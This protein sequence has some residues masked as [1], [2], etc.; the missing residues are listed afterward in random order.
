MLNVTLI[1]SISSHHDVWCPIVCQL[2]IHSSFI[3]GPNWFPRMLIDCEARGRFVLEGEL[4]WLSESS[5]T[6]TKRERGNDILVTGAIKRAWT[7][8]TMSYYLRQSETWDEIM[9]SVVCVFVCVCVCVCVCVHRKSCILLAPLAQYRRC[10]FMTGCS[11][12]FCASDDSQFLKKYILLTLL[13]H[14]WLLTPL[15][16]PVGQQGVDNLTRFSEPLMSSRSFFH[17]HWCKWSWD[18]G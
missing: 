2:S 3:S 17:Q 6:E 1:K 7:L 12:T 13:Y 8:I 15:S 5:G 18:S 14:R 9:C 4:N 16:Q 10:S 11:R